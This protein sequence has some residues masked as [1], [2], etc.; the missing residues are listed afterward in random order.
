M[1][2]VEE[3]RRVSLAKI[4][5]PANNARNERRV[6]SSGKIRSTLDPRALEK[7]ERERERER[8]GGRRRSRDPTK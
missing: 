8:E 4:A 1:G 5:A 3:S 6:A 7:R 2:D